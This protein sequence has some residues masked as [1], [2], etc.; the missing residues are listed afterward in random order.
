METAP[1]AGLLMAEP[2]VRLTVRVAR[3]VSL[4]AAVLLVV[5]CYGDPHWHIHIRNESAV[6]LVIAITQDEPP[7]DGVAIRPVGF[8]ADAHVAGGTVGGVGDFH[9]WVTVREFASCRTFGSLKVDGGLII[10]VVSADGTIGLDK[11]GLPSSDA[12]QLE[13]TAACADVS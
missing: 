10:V 5:A 1:A 2:G 4:V 13:M 12:P 7:G 6:R 3:A 9:G 11:V 8:V